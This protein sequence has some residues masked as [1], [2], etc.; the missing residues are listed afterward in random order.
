MAESVAMVAGSVAST[1]S[2]LSLPGL[3]ISFGFSGRCD[4]LFIQS[5]VQDDVAVGGTC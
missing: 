3:P 5:V 4:A 2:F 1:S